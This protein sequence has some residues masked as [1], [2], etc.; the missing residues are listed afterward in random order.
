MFAFFL[1]LLFFF[2]VFEQILFLFL[3]RWSR[4]FSKRLRAFSFVS[5]VLMCKTGRE[6]QHMTEMDYATAT[7]LFVTDSVL[8]RAA[9]ETFF[10]SCPRQCI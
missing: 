4:F 6:E 9:M 5:L 1:L 10:H 7:L 2:F 3:R 8:R